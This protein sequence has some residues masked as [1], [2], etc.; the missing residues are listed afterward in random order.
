[1]DRKRLMQQKLLEISDF[2]I[3]KFIIIGDSNMKSAQTKIG[4]AAG[5]CANAN[6]V[7]RFSL[8]I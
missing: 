4:R 2:F 7:K 3:L 5:C 6:G 8:E 1:M